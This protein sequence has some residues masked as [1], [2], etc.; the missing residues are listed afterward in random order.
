MNRFSSIFSQLL[1]L[2]PRIEFQHLVNETQ[3]ERGAKGFTCWAQFVSMEFCQRGRAHSLREI[4]GGLRSCEGK[5]KRGRC[6][7]IDYWSRFGY[8]VCMLR[9]ARLDS[10][11]ALQ[12]GIVPGNQRRKI[13][14]DDADRRGVPDRL[15]KLLE[16]TETL[17][18]AWSLIPNHFQPLALAHPI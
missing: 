3:A 9:F 15:S 14:L 2:F 7:L 6:L 16:D 12:H 10:F 18:Y 11:G 8:M 1:Q 13:F 17:C 4:T 5:H